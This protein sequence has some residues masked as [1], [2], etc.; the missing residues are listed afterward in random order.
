MTSFQSSE[1]TELPVVENSQLFDQ[2]AHSA[3][4][5]PLLQQQAP[6]TTTT[7]SATQTTSAGKGNPAN[8]AGAF[9]WAGMRRHILM[10]TDFAFLHCVKRLYLSAPICLHERRHKH[11]ATSASARIAHEQHGTGMTGGVRASPTDCCLLTAD[12]CLPCHTA[13]SNLYSSSLEVWSKCRAGGLRCSA[14][15]TSTRLS[16]RGLP[17]EAVH[18]RSWVAAR[19]PAGNREQST[20]EGGGGRDAAISPGGRGALVAEGGTTCPCDPCSLPRR[21]VWLPTSARWLHWAPAEA[22]PAPHPHHKIHQDLSV[23]GSAGHPRMNLINTQATPQTQ[24]WTLGAYQRIAGGPPLLTSKTQADPTPTHIRRLRLRGKMQFINWARDVRPI[25]GTQTFFFGPSDPLGRD[26]RMGLE[27]GS[28]RAR[29]S[30]HGPVSAIAAAT[31]VFLRFR[32][33]S[34]SF[35]HQNCNGT[36]DGAGEGPK[37]S[38]PPPGV[39]E[40]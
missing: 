25:L 8:E 38:P 13:C 9:H 40:Q 11:Q 34:F 23:A 17:R 30:G 28:P 33:Q 4:Y 2:R 29:W 7:T 39:L 37:Q 32:E 27:G 3:R 36:I 24:H 12:C 35:P 22:P 16:T 21:L 31:Q 6:T 26:K 20:T 10:V 19:V 18:Q 15:V 14:T 5:A 1:L